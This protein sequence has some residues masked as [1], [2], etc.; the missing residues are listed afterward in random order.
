TGFSATYLKV[1]TQGVTLIMLGNCEALSDPFYATGGMETN[2]FANVFLRLFV[3]EDLLGR[4]LPDP[5]WSRAPHEFA[6]QVK[7]LSEPTGGKGYENTIADHDEL[8]R[9]LDGRK[10]KA[11]VTMKMDP[12]AFDEYLGRYA[13][14]GSKRIFTAKRE[15]SRFIMDFD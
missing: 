6:D 5:D 10:A 4:T 9:W 14:D 8:T 7:R 3:F 12:R 1:P 11:R 15:G 13:L 2:A